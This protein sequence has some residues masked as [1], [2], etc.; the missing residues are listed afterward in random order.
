MQTKTC[1]KCRLLKPRDCFYPDKKRKDGLRPWCKSCS[2]TAQKEYRNRPETK[3]LEH[4]Q[5]R[6]LTYRIAGR[7]RQRK[8]RQKPSVR[9]S[10][11]KSGKARMATQMDKMIEYNKSAYKKNPK[12]FVA[13]RILNNAV[14]AGK[15]IKPNLCQQ[16]HSVRRIHGHHDDYNKP[17]EVKWLCT[18]CH[19]RLHWKEA[20]QYALLS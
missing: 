17:L 18:Y 14:N 7:L 20:E 16:C 12:K 15:I 11:I 9:L 3:E 8:H 5:Y 19:G 4:K 6:T 13:R 10:E 1:S 2:E